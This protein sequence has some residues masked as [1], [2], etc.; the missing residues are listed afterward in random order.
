M[1]KTD[2]IVHRKKRI[3]EIKDQH[4]IKLELAEKIKQFKT[5]EIPLDE[6]GNPIE[7]T[8]S[9][10]GELA[11]IEPTMK[12]DSKFVNKMLTIL[13]DNQT[14][15]NST[16]TGKCTQNPNQCQRDTKPLDMNKVLY[17]R[18]LFTKRVKKEKVKKVERKEREKMVNQLVNNKICNLRK[19]EIMKKT[20][21]LKLK[22]EESL[23]D[24]FYA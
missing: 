22:E 2:Q 21:L 3:A 12:G 24:P 18:Q 1:A 23:E 20:K 7:M 6:D 17:M 14:L 11:D 19:G 13:F 5:S 8:D 9:D 10:V 4:Q 16:I 15:L